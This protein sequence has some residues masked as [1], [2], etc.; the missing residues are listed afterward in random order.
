FNRN[1][2]TDTAGVF[3]VGFIPSELPM[4]N[5]QITAGQDYDSL[6]YVM[7]YAKL[8][9]ININDTKNHDIHIFKVNSRIGGRI[10]INGNSPN[11]NLPLMIV[12]N[13]SCIIYRMTTPEGY[14]SVPV[15][16]K[17]FNYT[18]NPYNLMQNISYAY[19]IAHPGQ[20]NVLLNLTYSVD[21]KPE[22]NNIPDEYTL[23]QNYPNPFNP[24]TKISYSIPKE[25]NVK[26]T[27]YNLIGS[28]VAV[29]VDEYKP[30]GNYSIDFNGKDL[31]SGIYFYKLESGNFTSVKKL[32]F[33][34]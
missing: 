12:N 22:N 5:V 23:N 29:L 2:R 28:R 4:P 16:D 9:Q 24:A 20:T 30:A 14:F 25:G 3:Y 27:V 34:K 7:G 21:V 31:S 10:L 18:I 17:V 1:G 33:L 32:T 19:L 6:N 26:L 13:D 11:Q 8:G 15:S